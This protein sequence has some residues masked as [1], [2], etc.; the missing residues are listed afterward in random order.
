M[1]PEPA[2]LE[3]RITRGNDIVFTA[4]GVSGAALMTWGAAGG[5]WHVSPSE[6]Q[7]MRGD[8]LVVPFIRTFGWQGAVAVATL[9]SGWAGSLAL[10]AL[11]RLFDHRAAIT[12]DEAG[13]VFH[14]S[15]QKTRLRWDEVQAVRLSTGPY[16]KLEIE[17]SGRFWSTWG[18]LTSQRLSI[19]LVALGLTYREG[20]RTVRT[21]RGWMK[22][23]TM[24]ERV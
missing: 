21:M 19:P 12:A 1:T 4:I 10:G 13:V 18:W 5:L 16:A 22:I 24:P 11:W 20:T 23:A 14:P 7:G 6:F 8:W 3:L 2:S 15:L 9:F 17:F